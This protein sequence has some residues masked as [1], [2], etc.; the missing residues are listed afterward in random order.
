MFISSLP[1]QTE[2]KE[3]E[4]EFLSASGESQPSLDPV[5]Q[6]SEIRHALEFVVRQLDAKMIFQPR[7]QIERLQA[8]DAE[9]LKE[10]VIRGE[11]LSRHF[12]VSRCKVQYLIK[13]L[14][15]YHHDHITFG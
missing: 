5:G 6:R 8:V 3:R 9:R 13:C 1:V 10:V 14:F 15:M 7:Q 2:N 11:P 12:E 4:P